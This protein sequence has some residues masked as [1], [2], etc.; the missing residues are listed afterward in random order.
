MKDYYIILGLPK[1]ASK[2][3]IKQAYRQK[4]KA[5]H[6]DKCSTSENRQKFM[7]AKEAYDTLSDDTRRA[8]YDRALKRQQDRHGVTVNT[9]RKGGFSR[10]KPGGAPIRDI[11]ETPYA[12]D[13]KSIQELRLQLILSPEE[14]QSGGRF[15]IN[16]PITRLCSHGI[17]GDLLLQFFCPVCNGNGHIRSE[18]TVFLE[19]PPYIESGA[20]FRELAHEDEGTKI[21]INAEI[22][23]EA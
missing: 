4:A 18:K 11:T 7:E 3:R 14:A 15:P 8:E 19:I 1:A 20:C 13:F 10:R 6:P 21:F 5:H 9:S 17:H 23:I 12:R 16:V 2:N 22:L